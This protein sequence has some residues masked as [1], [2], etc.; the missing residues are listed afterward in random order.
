MWPPNTRK[1]ASKITL[2]SAITCGNFDYECI[3]IIVP[4]VSFVK[5]R[6]SFRAR[7]RASHEERLFTTLIIYQA[8]LQFLSLELPRLF[9]PLQVR[10]LPDGLFSP[11]VRDKTVRNRHQHSFPTEE[12]SK[13]PP[14]TPRGHVSPNPNL[15]K[16]LA[17]HDHRSP[18]L[19]GSRG[20][21]ITAAAA[22]GLR[23]V[24][25]A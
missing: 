25:W 12:E 21:S 1:L 17:E 11:V 13:W 7:L 24:T 9:I 20:T 22:E 14:R 4:T 10:F 19:S 16:W 18:F 3:A 15:Q 6:V 5:S 8:W 23:R 2:R